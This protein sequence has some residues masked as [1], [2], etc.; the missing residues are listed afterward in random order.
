MKGTSKFFLDLYSP[1]IHIV[2]VILILFLRTIWNCFH[3]NY[4]YKASNW[5]I[6]TKGWW[7][8]SSLKGVVRGSIPLLGLSSNE[9]SY[10]F[11]SSG[12]FED[13]CNGIPTITIGSEI[14]DH[15]PLPEM[16]FFVV[17]LIIKWDFFKCR[18]Y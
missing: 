7:K 2:S 13:D 15:L 1:L 11:I 3:Q 10:S 9:L 12:E 8:L 14:L 18:L 4:Q 16:D 17:T 6:N 5:M